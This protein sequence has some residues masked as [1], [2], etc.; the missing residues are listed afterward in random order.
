MITRVTA[1]TF[2]QA[3]RLQSRKIKEEIEKGDFQPFG[4]ARFEPASYGLAPYWLIDEIIQQGEISFWIGDPGVGKSTIMTALAGHVA[5]KK[6]I[7]THRIIGNSN[8]A[9]IAALEDYRGVSRSVR[10]WEHYHQ[11]E[12]G[13]IGVIN[14]D[15]DFVSNERDVAYFAEEIEAYSGELEGSIKLIVID[16]LSDCFG[17]H[18]QNDDQAMMAFMHNLRMV[19]SHSLSDYHIAVV[20]HHGAQK[21]SGGYGSTVAWRKFDTEIWISRLASD[22]RQCE[23]KK[24]RNGQ[25]GIKFQFDFQ[26]IETEF[27]D[28]FGVF[29]ST[30]ELVAIPR[31]K[32]S[33]N[34]AYFIEGQAA[35][36]LNALEQ[37]TAA[38]GVPVRDMP[39]KLGVSRSAWRDAAY[40]LLSG[41]NET[42]RQ[43]FSRAEK[44]I[45]GHDFANKVNDLIVPKD[46]PKRLI[47]I[48]GGA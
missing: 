39:D 44:K 42:K 32:A 23:I 4:P 13:R 3:R 15:W 20:H 31:G 26:E 38:E 34:G 7:G 37:I 48:N 22:V 41:S 36:V 6:P 25:D 16:T 33:E 21:K 18:S 10:S 1:D 14:R 2:W 8:L 17:G 47:S 19:M 12:E 43:A 46:Q 9:L 11:V 27:R 29:K 24:Q 40:R 30:K 28:D 35:V 5:H 45:L